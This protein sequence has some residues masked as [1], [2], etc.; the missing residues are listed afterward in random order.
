MQSKF[1]KDL[2]RIIRF[3]RHRNL[4]PYHNVLGH[5]VRNTQEYVRL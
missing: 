1:Y 5:E 4:H 2:E 3:P